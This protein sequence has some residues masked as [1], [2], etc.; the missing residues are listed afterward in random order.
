MLRNVPGGHVDVVAGQGLID[1]QDAQAARL[2]LL[3]VDLHLNLAHQ[4]AH[5]RDLA[6]ASGAFQSLLDLVLG[7]ALQSAQVAVA[8]HGQQQDGLRI[9]IEFADGRVSGIG[10]QLATNRG[11]L[12]LDVDGAVF[13]GSVGEEN[14][15]RGDA[16]DRG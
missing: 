10:R 5:Q 13:G 4:A 14:D 8:T 2:Q 6:D 11:D 16:L 7:Q 9:G 1:L 3:L 15:D 12:A